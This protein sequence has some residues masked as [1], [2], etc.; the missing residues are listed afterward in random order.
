AHFAGTLPKPIAKD[1]RPLRK[2]AV[3]LGRLRM[4]FLEV[5]K[6]IVVVI[7]A[8]GLVG[9]WAGI[10]KGRNDFTGFL[11]ENLGRILGMQ[12]LEAAF[13]TAHDDKESKSQDYGGDTHERGARSEPGF[14]ARGSDHLR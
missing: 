7:E 12:T 14:F 8:V 3:P 11:G 5:R 4:T 2:H 13:L 9:G 1:R 10:T 6:K